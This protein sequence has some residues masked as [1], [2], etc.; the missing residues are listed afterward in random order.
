MEA[1]P[2]VEP[3]SRGPQPRALSLELT[4]LLEPTSALRL[5]AAVGFAPTTGCFKGICSPA[6]L[7]GSL[8][9]AEAA[10]FEP[11]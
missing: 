9:L 8:K 5:E 2:G 10:G 7:R 6:E 1:R 3:G 4:G 11:A